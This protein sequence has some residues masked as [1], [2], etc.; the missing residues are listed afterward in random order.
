MEL[1]IYQKVREI[2]KDKPD[3]STPVFAKDIMHIEQGIKDN[4]INSEKLLAKIEALES[5]VEALEP[6]NIVSWSEGANAEIVAMVNGLRSGK[7]TADD[8]GWQVGDERTVDLSAIESEYFG[9]VPAQ[10]ATLVILNKGGKLLEDGNECHFV[11]G[12]KNCIIDMYKGMNDEATSEGGWD[13]CGARDAMNNDIPKMIPQDLLSIFV[14]FQNITAVGTGE[15]TTTSID[16]FALPA[17]KEAL[18]ANKY[19]NSTAESELSQF[20]YYEIQ[21]RRIKRI[22]DSGVGVTKTWWLRSSN[23]TSNLAFCCI[24]DSGTASAKNAQNTNTFSPFGCI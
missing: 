9:S 20:E 7:I 17:E 13:A 10:S 14:N 21:N 1:K 2:W 15:A 5:R 23:D 8:T 6:I 12:F 18:G 24:S 19:A 11:V 22:G 16:R 3:K 4:S